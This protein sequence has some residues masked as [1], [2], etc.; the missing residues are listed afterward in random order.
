MKKAEILIHRGVPTTYSYHIPDNLNVSLGAAVSIPFGKSN[1]TGHVVQI[2][3]KASEQSLKDIISVLDNLPT[4]SEELIGLIQ[5]FREAYL[6]SPFKAYE[7]IVGKKQLRPLPKEKSIKPNWPDINLTDEQKTVLSCLKKKKTFSETLIHG[8]T[9]SG[10]TEIYLQL[11]KTL[12]EAKKQVLI[13]IPEISLTPQFYERFTERFGNKVVLLHSGQTKKQKEEAW[14][15]IYAQKSPIVIG[16]RSA[17]FAPLNNLGAIIIDECHDQSFKQDSHPRYHTARIAQWRALKQNALLIY[18][19]ATPSIDHYYLTTIT[20]PNSQQLCELKERVNKKPFPPIRLIDLTTDS[21]T[22]LI[23]DS[24]L[25]KIQE[26]L[27]KKQKVIL[28]VNRRGYAPYI[29]CK[30]CKK[31]HSCNECGLSYTYHKDHSFRCHRCHITIPAANTCKHCGLNTLNF[32]GTGTQKIELECKKLFPDAA[33]LRLDKDT[34][35]TAKRTEAIISQFRKSGDILIGT[36]M[37]TKGHDI[38]EVTLVG[39]IGID[40]V[41]NIP[42]YKSTERT[43]QLITQVAG[44]A[45]RADQEGEVYCET[46]QPNHYAIQAAQ[47]Y[48]YLSFYNKEISF[49]KLLNYPPFTELM[50]IILSSKY[51]DYIKKTAKDIFQRL[52]DIN[53]NMNDELVIMEPG[54]APIEKIKN[55]YRY[56]ILIKCPPNRLR[57]LKKACQFLQDYPRSIRII[58]DIDPWNLL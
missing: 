12:L 13:L 49:R 35:S 53:K 51:E 9:A 21:K 39:I 8:V 18:G 5:W 43:F 27:T 22:G 30:K 26:A 40:S 1:A 19:S 55:I 36:Q 37:I 46:Y 15:K 41:L 20:A 56:H 54:P 58:P 31:I 45:G 24:L 4:L 42:D 23:S 2:T 50:N 3:P 48:D 52:T 28:F 33:I 47:N 44:R 11:A 38:P 25:K 14:S 6:T 32:G 57:A 10:K 17:V 29:V 16:P 34:G 7:T